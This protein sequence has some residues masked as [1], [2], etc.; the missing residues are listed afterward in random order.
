[1]IKNS[2]IRQPIPIKK[3]ILPL[4]MFD[5]ILKFIKCLFLYKNLFI[6]T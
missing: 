3:F 5:F 1:M 2:K 6:I 4:D